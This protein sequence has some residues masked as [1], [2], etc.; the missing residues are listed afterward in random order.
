MEV[1]ELS[2]APSNPDRVI[3]H[4]SQKKKKKKLLAL[5]ILQHKYDTVARKHTP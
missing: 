1:H 4:L 2:C 3:P 5:E